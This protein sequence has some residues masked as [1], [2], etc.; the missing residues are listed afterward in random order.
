M[1][2]H[3]PG[4]I[5]SLQRCATLHSWNSH[6]WFSLA[7]AYERVTT[8]SIPPQNGNFED[9]NRGR[10]CLLHQD[11]TEKNCKKNCVMGGWPSQETDFT[12]KSC[13]ASNNKVQGPILTKSGYSD[14][15]EIRQCFAHLA[16]RDQGDLPV[17]HIKHDCHFPSAIQ[18]DEGAGV[19]HHS[20]Y[21][22]WCSNRKCSG[23]LKEDG[24]S[25]LFASN[26]KHRSEYCGCV[27]D[28]LKWRNH[29]LAFGSLVKSR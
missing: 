1:F 7:L 26:R 16:V 2:V 6:F 28:K 4:E 10:N 13:C 22:I 23:S 20:D 15:L 12:V 21:T 18:L 29:V 5:E 9:G 25:C 24:N 11:S 19:Q 17:V 14:E 8:S 3:P 27:K